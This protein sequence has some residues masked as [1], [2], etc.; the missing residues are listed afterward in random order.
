[1]R[2]VLLAHDK[3]GP[4]TSKTAVC[5]LRYSKEYQT[6]AVID[7]SKAGRPASEF[8][9]DIGTN[10]P[11]VA[12]L[13]E[14]LRFQPE[15]LIIGI[16]PIGGTLPADWR[17][18]LRLAL[19]N[20]VQIVSGL[21]VFLADDPELGP[22]ARRL[23]VRIWDVRR[24]ERADRIATGE[25]LRA[26]ALVVH[27]MGTD[28]NSGKMTT[29]VEIVRE[30]R[31]RGIH[32]AFAATGQTGIMIGCDAGA[33]IDRVISD[34]VAGAAEELVLECDRNGFDLVCVEGQG[35]A[36][37]PAYSGVTIGL[38]HG[39][40]PDQI[41]L[42]HQHAREFKGE[43]GTAGRQFRTLS[44]PEEIRLIEALLA[45]VSGGKV[46]A[47]SLATFAVD[48]AEARRAVAQAERE[49]G[50]P[51][52]DPIRFGPGKL[53]DAIVAASQS[54]PKEGAIRLRALA[55]SAPR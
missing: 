43:Y 38:M 8:V 42:C 48:E 14:A 47:V 46:V 12:H 15:V 35:A 52:T 5:I 3:F 9:G 6:V 2:A 45:P 39:C 4:L 22:L 37:H 18:E 53:V 28:C 36:T 50:L 16:A 40:F 20:K 30:A 23:G 49:T 19:E 55:A 11:I 32:A 29:S 13:R 17:Q 27:T 31:R 21:H 26:K 7:R 34:F 1:M 24:P 41:V 10:V 51:A 54:S 25:G 33:P 44:L